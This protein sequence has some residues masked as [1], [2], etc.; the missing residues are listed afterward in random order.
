M[1]IKRVSIYRYN[2]DNPYSC[3]IDIDYESGAMSL[4]LDPEKVNEIIEVVR[5]LIVD[6]A[7][8]VADTLKRDAMSI[9]AIEHKPDSD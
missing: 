8:N 7:R 6:G 9:G 1:N 2:N 3:D 5:D 4:K